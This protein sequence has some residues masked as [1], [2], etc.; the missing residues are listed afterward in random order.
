MDE[1]NHDLKDS[2]LGEE[3]ASRDQV[4][5]ALPLAAWQ[6]TYQTLHLWSADRR[7]DTAHAQP[8]SQPLVGHD[9]IHDSTRLD[10]LDDPL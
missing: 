1:R 5:P 6:D 3:Q 10:D 2:A 8:A 9:A 7:K 4:W